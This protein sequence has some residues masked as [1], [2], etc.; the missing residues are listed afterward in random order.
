MLTYSYDP[1]SERLLEAQTFRGTKH[2]TL[3]DPPIDEFSVIMTRLPPG[4]DELHDGIAGPSILIVVDGVGG[5]IESN[6]LEKGYHRI[7]A[8]GEVFF[9]GANVPIQFTAEPDHPL[10]IYRAF[11]EA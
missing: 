7:A 4:E 1:A 6:G 11:V 8:R 10:V 2:S 5:K 3:Y 9:V